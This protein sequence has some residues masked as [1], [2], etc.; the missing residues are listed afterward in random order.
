[1]LELDWA[2]LLPLR[3]FGGSGISRGPAV[4]FVTALF[5]RRKASGRSLQSFV[6]TCDFVRGSTP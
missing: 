3:G 1:M 2:V 6:A 4:A 5:C